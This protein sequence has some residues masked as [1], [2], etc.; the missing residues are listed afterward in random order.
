MELKITRMSPEDVNGAFGVIKTAFEQFVAPGYSREGILEFY[1]FA[2]PLAIS[3]RLKENL[4]LS[5]K[6]SD[7]RIAGIIEVKNLNHISLLFVLPEYH[8][9]GIAR[10]LVN[11]AEAI[12]GPHAALEVN[13]S[14]YAVPVYERLGFRAQ[15]AEREQNGI[16]YVPMLK[17]ASGMKIK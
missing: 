10:Q 17:P 8:R 15:S 4:L 6:I 9:Q 3:R 13:A 11:R 1:K 2:N 16:R 5:A 7:G 14:P 12:C